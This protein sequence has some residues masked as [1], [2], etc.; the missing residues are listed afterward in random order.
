MIWFTGASAMKSVKIIIKL[1]V[2][3]FCVAYMYNELTLASLR[4]L[5][6]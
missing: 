3:V 6:L 1:G 2:H 4:H 5:E